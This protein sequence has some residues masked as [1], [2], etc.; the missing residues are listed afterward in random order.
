MSKLNAFGPKIQSGNIRNSAWCPCHQTPSFPCR[1]PGICKRLQGGG[2]TIRFFTKIEVRKSPTWDEQWTRGGRN[3]FFNSH[4]APVSKFVNLRQAIF[5][6]CSDSGYSHR[7]NRNLPMFLLKKWPH[8]LMLQ[9][10]LKSNSWYGSG[11]PQILTPGSVLSEISDFTPCPHASDSVTQVSDSTR[12]TIFGDAD[13]SH[14]AK[15][16]D[17]KLDSTRV[18]VNDSRLESEKFLQDLWVPDSQT[19]FVCT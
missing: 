14:V 2:L 1:R 10:K 5:D 8:C 19:H 4:S 9:K 16:G 15:N 7:F 11:F 12:V 13:S 3:R 17:S 18:T 6:F